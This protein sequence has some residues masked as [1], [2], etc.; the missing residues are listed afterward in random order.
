[1]D[2]EAFNWEE[3]SKIAIGS[4]F[5]DSPHTLRY[6]R[7]QHTQDVFQ[8]AGRDDY[9]KEGRAGAFEAARDKAIALINSPL[10]DGL[11]NEDQVNEIKKVV[12]AADVDIIG[13]AQ[14]HA[15]KREVI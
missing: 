14:G 15:G 3:V 10:P 13:K 12:A 7:T 4:H 8:R 11:P 6:C 9:E 5:L 1:V 2:D